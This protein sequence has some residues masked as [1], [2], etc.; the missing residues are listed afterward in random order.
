MN[1]TAL[2]LSSILLLCIS[3]A[4]AQKDTS[5]DAFIESYKNN[6]MSS[7]LASG[8][9]EKQKKACNCVLNNVLNNFSPSELKNEAEVTKYIQNVALL[10][11][12]G[13]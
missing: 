1:R 4:Q 6:F 12:E 13:Q 2:A 7:C 9:D 3:T 10:N 8:S 11:C 5:D